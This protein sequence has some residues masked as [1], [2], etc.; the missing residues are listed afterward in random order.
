MAANGNL[1]FQDTNKATFVGANSNVV[2]DTVNASFGVG[3]DVN[4][5]T[6][7]LHVVGNAYV[8][9]NLEVGTGYSDQLIP[10]M[11]GRINNVNI[12]ALNERTRTSYSTANN[13]V[14]AWTIRSISTGSKWNSVTWS[15]ELSLFVAVA[16]TSLLSTPNELVATSPDGVT[17]TN[18]TIDVG[19]WRYV[20][21]SPELSLFVAVASSG[22]N[23]V[24]TSPDGIT[25]TGRSI[26]ANNW[27]G[28]TWSPELSL[29]VAVA[30]TGTNR[31]ATSPDGITWTS[32]SIE[33]SGW[34]S[35]TWSPELSLFVAVAS[36][37]TNRVATSP[38]GITWTSRSIDAN[39]WYGVTWSPELSLFVAV[40][41][42]GTNRVA[43]SP[44]GITWTGRSIEASGWHSVTWSPELSLFVAVAFSGTNRVAT[45][46]DGIMWTGRTIDATSWYS[47][48][49]SPE[50]SLFVVVAVNGTNRAATSNIGIPAPLNT[51]MS[52][53]G[54]LH[55][56][57]INSRVGVGTTNPQQNLHVHEAGS[58]QVVI[59]VTNDTTGSGVNDGIH[60]GVDSNEIGFVWHKP[61]TQLKF[62]THNTERMRVDSGVTSVVAGGTA[63]KGVS[64]AHAGIAIDRVWSNYPSITV[65]NQNSTGDTRQSQL[66]IHGCNVSY[67]SY[68]STSGSDFGCSIYIDG[69]Y[70]TNSDRRFK[71]NITTIDNALHKVM[72][73][74]GK[75][76]QLLNADGSIRTNV[77]TN[78]YKYGF[79]AQD[80][81]ALGLNETFIHY[82]EED[83]GTEGYNKA[84]SVDYDSFIPLLVNAIKEQNTII[85]T[86]KNQLET[87]RN[88]NDELEARIL[89]LENAS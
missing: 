41:S 89:A 17:W 24:A 26:D 16:Q 79:I 20:I 87:E 60:F 4:G 82:T 22:T 32:R 40:A 70:Q 88:R 63:G 73:L 30:Q 51:P 72:S 2:I 1:I 62:A 38:D 18:R 65:M 44:D 6:S 69:T 35:V 12:T 15:P 47:V 39:S 43:T 11:S 36:S 37:D 66:R 23:R 67:S 5:P 45:S 7:N 34:R 83:D 10:R 55:V 8:T 76:Y 31:V 28:V 29:L 61:N 78:D 85:D 81:E 13:A 48:T 53:P 49:W 64:F 54:Q 46:P 59:A 21:W 27:Y 80:L 56:D 71:T 52:H 77:S 84:Y 50:L 74:S 75:R 42:S 14:S 86:T 19:Y 58:G 3:V 33:A 25:W 68:P 57:T 9:S